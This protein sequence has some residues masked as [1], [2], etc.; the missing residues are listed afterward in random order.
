M[1]KNL[2]HHKPNSI[3]KPAI[4]IER[5]YINIMTKKQKITHGSKYSV[6]CLGTKKGFDKRYTCGSL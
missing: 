3:S 2:G 5:K 1:S 4:E 6:S